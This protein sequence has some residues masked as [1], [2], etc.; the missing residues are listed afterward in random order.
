MSPSRGSDPDSRGSHLLAACQIGNNFARQSARGGATGGFVRMPAVF[1]SACQE[2][3][4]AVL[5]AI[6]AAG[7]ERR[8]L[9]TTAKRAVA[10]ASHDAHSSAEWRLAD[11]L[12]RGIE[13]VEARMQDAA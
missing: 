4:I 2:A 5:D 1:A 11:Q 3:M 13:D 12:R 8:G 7:N 10:T 9:L 6:A